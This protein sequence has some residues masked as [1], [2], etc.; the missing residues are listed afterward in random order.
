MSEEE[1]K[2]PN[3]RERLKA[4]GKRGFELSEMERLGFWPPDPET[5]LKTKD[6]QA[7]LRAVHS[8]MLPLRRR[9]IELEKEMANAADI[10]VALAEVRTRRIER[11]KAERAQRKIRKAQER[12][13]KREA[14]KAWRGGILPY[15]GRGVSAGLNFEGGDGEKLK[16]FGLPILSNAEE[17]AGALQISTSKLA[18]LSYHRGAAAI[19]HY[20]HF[21]IPKKS[22]GERK[23]SAPKS[24]LRAAQEWIAQNILAPAPIHEAAMAFRPKICIAD[25]A[26]L[27]AGA[28]VVV[29]IDLKD[30]F[31][32]IT[33]RRIKRT[34]QK[35]G[36]NEGVATIFAL[37]CSES[38][39]VALTL[40]GTKHFV[41]LTERFLPQG[42]STSPSITNILCRDLDARLTGAAQT[43]G[44]IYTRYADDL[45][46]SA[47]EEKRV[48]DE[49]SRLGLLLS[50]V[51]QIVADEKFEINENKTAIMR[52]HRRQTVTGLVINEVK[53]T[54]AGSST[55]AR[56]SRRDLRKFRAFLHRYEKLGREAMTAQLGQ[57][58]L[59][60]AR[61]YLCFV[62]MVDAER[63][64]QF[65]AAHSW[66]DVINH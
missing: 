1:T 53:S 37:L 60:Y 29:R 20:H 30:F 55:P 11:V 4:L 25:N 49:P 44:F 22:G 56:V 2:D 63:A 48:E 39:R 5:V 65:R 12:E 34:F 31:P 3:W 14:D 21:T 52:P 7:E 28:Q 61:G 59:S 47:R 19:D 6:T 45:V 27:H 42:A 24:Q 33:F 18:W 62:H 54:A 8:E 16:S 64:A 66:L 32:S 9:M 43:Y 17:I 35:L 13:E 26:A 36:Y 10:Q 51:E 23:I 41:V 58:A 46:F 15:L 57:D 40:D 38:P 50:L